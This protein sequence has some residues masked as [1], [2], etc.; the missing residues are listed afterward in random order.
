[1][2]GT[3]IYVDLIKLGITLFLIALGLIIGRMIER[4]HF[5]SLARREAEPGPILT[6]LEKLLPGMVPISC[7][8]CVGSVVIAS[9]YFKSFGASLK[10]LVGGRLRTLE[11][12]LER[13]RREAMLRLRDQAAQTGADL[14]LNVRLE[15]SVVMR[16]R[17]GKGAPVTEVIAYG[18]AVKLRRTADE[19]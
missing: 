12:L 10:T 1:M 6:N 15:T 2:L 18:T 5:R 7:T 3:H 11:T 17:G 14:L 16:R 4:R 19:Q 9:D 8:F 13:A